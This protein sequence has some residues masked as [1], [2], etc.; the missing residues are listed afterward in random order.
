M[1]PPRSQEA[2]GMESADNPPPSATFHPLPPTPACQPHPPPSIAITMSMSGSWVLGRVQR[3]RAVDAAI[4]Y[5]D[6]GSVTC[7]D[8]TAEINVSSG[9]EEF[10]AHAINQDE[11]TALR[12]A[13]TYLAGGRRNPPRIYVDP[14]RIVNSPELYGAFMRMQENVRDGGHLRSRTITKVRRIISLAITGTVTFGLFWEGVGRG[15]EEIG[16]ARGLTNTEV[17]WLR[18]TVSAGTFAISHQFLN[19]VAG[20]LEV[21]M[22]GRMRAG[23]REEAGVWMKLLSIAA[24]EELGAIVVIGGV[25]AAVAALPRTSSHGLSALRDILRFTPS[26]AGVS[27]WE[28]LIERYLTLRPQ[29]VTLGSRRR[30]IASQGENIKHAMATAWN[31]SMGGRRFR[32]NMVQTVAKFLG[33]LCVPPSAVFLSQLFTGQDD[34]SSASALTRF[35]HLFAVNATFVAEFLILGQRLVALI[36][37]IGEQAAGRLT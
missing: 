22:G 13:F 29:Y 3:L 10:L 4:T 25:L 9:E 7:G 1:R 14:E 35:F 11:A 6:G 20:M 19:P 32:R 17:F 34:P 12:S 15:V 26:F 8:I 28:I 27:M 37:L 21:L 5:H 18:N 23:Q 31:D 33:T 30:D 16:R 2:C 24:S 36:Y